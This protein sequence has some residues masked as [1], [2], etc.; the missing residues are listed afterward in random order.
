VQGVDGK[1]EER[2]SGTEG[3]RLAEGHPQSMSGWYLLVSEQLDAA[4]EKCRVLDVI[5][6]RLAEDG[7]RQ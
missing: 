4:L 3:K 1:R 6:G 7:E 5:E 2:M